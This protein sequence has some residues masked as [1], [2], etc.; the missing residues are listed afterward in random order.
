M[1][2]MHTHMQ[3][4]FFHLL[5]SHIRLPLAL[6]PAAF[7]EAGFGQLCTPAQ[8]DASA[9]SIHHDSHQQHALQRQLASTSPD[10]SRSSTSSLAAITPTSM[11]QTANPGSQC[12]HGTSSKAVRAVSEQVVVASCPVTTTNLATCIA[13]KAAYLDD[14]HGEKPAA[15]ASEGRQPPA[16]LL[17]QQEVAGSGMKQFGTT[18]SHS[19]MGLAST[20]PATALADQNGDGDRAIGHPDATLKACTPVT[21]VRSA[22]STTTDGKLSSCQAE[23]RHNCERTR[24]AHSPSNSPREAATCRVSITQSDSMC[25]VDSHS[26]QGQHF[27]A[28]H[29]QHVSSVSDPLQQATP[30]SSATAH[31]AFEVKQSLR[32]PLAAGKKLSTTAAA[33]AQLQCCSPADSAAAAAQALT[34]CDVHDMT[35]QLQTLHLRPSLADAAILTPLQQL[36]RVCEQQVRLWNDCGKDVDL[37]P[38]A[39]S[40][41]AAAWHL[42]MITAFCCAVA[43]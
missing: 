3:H 11:Q 15:A 8:S 40:C 34:H 37:M 21:T 28:S 6:C 12:P 42:N 32:L 33:M 36:L 31:T 43:V 39:A 7:P 41:S 5:N 24:L 18:P 27:A 4:K 23:G 38:F 29:H 20:T 22:E 16:S 2:V 13:G 25:M 14:V 35:A 30:N 17:S 26:P 9:A 1:Q 10:S 19:S